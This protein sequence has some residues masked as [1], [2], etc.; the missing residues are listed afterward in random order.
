M[1]EDQ[2]NE[3]DEERRQGIQQEGVAAG[4]PLNKTD[5]QKRR[6]W[7]SHLLCP[8]F[9]GALPSHPLSGISPL[10]PQTVRDDLRIGRG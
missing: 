5:E 10:R 1:K 3:E 6:P 9:S 2:E 8:K 4:T 7:T